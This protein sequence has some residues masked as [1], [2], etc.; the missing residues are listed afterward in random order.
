VVASAVLLSGVLAGCSGLRPGA[1]IVVG[2][3][4]VSD[5]R[6]QAVQ[7][8]L[9]TFLGA[10]QVSQGAP[11]AEVPARA[12]ALTSLQFLLRGT[13]AEQ[14]AQREGVELTRQEVREYVGALPVSP[15][16]V[17]PAERD[18]VLAAKE[19]IARTQLLTD[20]LGE[21]GS[22]NLTA[23]GQQRI[24]EYL[25]EVGYEVQP[26]YGQVVDTE[27]KPGTGSMSVAVSD[28]GVRGLDLPQGGTTPEAELCS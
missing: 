3:E 14:L 4:T 6:F 18:E 21:R 7:H 23:A 24:Q 2:D 12:V 16:S 10:Y 17:P 27:S 26:R 22:G 15:D 25:D 9:C 11:E 28:E 1:A 5:D 8:D 13:A 20:K 19:L